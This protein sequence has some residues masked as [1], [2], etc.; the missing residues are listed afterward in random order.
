M[1][2]G[3]YDRKITTN[4]SLIEIIKVMYLI[5]RYWTVSH[6]NDE[7]ISLLFSLSFSLLIRIHKITQ[8][9][10]EMYFSS[11]VMLLSSS[12]A[13]A[14]MRNI[15][16]LAVFPDWICFFSFFFSFFLLVSLLPISYFLFLSFSHYTFFLHFC[17]R[18]QTNKKQ[19]KLSRLARRPIQAECKFY[20]KVYV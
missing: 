6:H 16:V 19:R 12:S 11:N 4:T 7:F 15:L 14:Q 17:H 3:V 20:I 9:K 5:Q 1:I 18:I 2:I 8:Y 10:N 13:T